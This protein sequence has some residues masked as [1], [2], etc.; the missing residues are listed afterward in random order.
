MMKLNAM[1]LLAG[2]FILLAWPDRALAEHFN[3]E[4]EVSG[5]N[6]AKARAFVDESPPDQGRNPRPVFK[7]LA[8]DALTVQFMM[9]NIFPHETIKD[10]GIR[11]YVVKENQLGQK[12]LPD[13][14]RGVMTEGTFNLDLKPQARVGARFRLVID[15][16]GIY[17]LRV[18]SLRTQNS[19]EHF[20]AVDLEIE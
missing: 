19:H 3:I 6:G 9:T 1:C 5:A 20:S 4:L 2:G 8:G 18:E 7:A 16:P 13:T 15:Q 11:Y 10:A 14:A 17:L 12:T